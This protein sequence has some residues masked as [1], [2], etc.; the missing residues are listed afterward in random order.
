ME[1][2][3]GPRHSKIIGDFAERL[4]CNFLWK[5]NRECKQRY[6]EDPGVMHVHMDLR[7]PHWWRG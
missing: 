2:D 5:M 7:A 6:A 4:V 3:K 1:I